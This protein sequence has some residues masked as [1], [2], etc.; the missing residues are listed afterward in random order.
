MGALRKAGVWLGLVEEDDERAYDDGGYEKGGYRDSRYRQSRYA[1]EFTD[2]D[3]DDAEEPPAPRPRDSGRGR[4]SERSSGRLSESE[5]GDGE[6]PERIERSSV[7][8]ITRSSAGETSGALTYH[9]RDNLALAPQ[10]TS[11]ERALP[12]EEQRYQITTLHPTTYREARTIGEHFRDGVPVI[13][14]LTEMDEAD[15][16]RLVDF[17]AGLAF[18]LRGTIERV[19]NR[20]FLLSPAN[21][22]VTAEDKAK[23]AEGGFF[24]LS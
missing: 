4:L 21:V 13:I 2:D 8:S 5:R 9:T 22:Q 16:R 19:T 14:N 10:V 11:R 17:A 15:A 3:E 20:V 1:E 24:S 7:R 23:I 18:G 6:R 12:E